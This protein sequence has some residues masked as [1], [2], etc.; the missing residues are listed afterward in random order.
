MLLLAL[1]KSQFFK[2]SIIFLY[3]AEIWTMTQTDG[4]D[5]EVFRNVSLWE[6]GKD[7]LSRQSKVS[8]SEVLQKVQENR[9]ILN[10]LKHSTAENL[11][12]YDKM[13]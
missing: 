12:G 13:S 7:Q 4:K 8:N 3:G 10:V 1:V 6:N 11:D 2:T 9:S 5:I